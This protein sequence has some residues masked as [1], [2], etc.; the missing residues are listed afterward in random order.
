[1]AVDRSRSDLAF[2]S[3][4]SRHTKA[5]TAR[6]TE[7]FPW[8]IF[9]VDFRFLISDLQ[10]CRAASYPTA[11]ARTAALRA[12]ASTSAHKRKATPRVDIEVWRAPAHNEHTR[13]ASA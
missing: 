1:M 5:Q 13:P 2:A 3:T 8:S 12:W 9:A 11:I 7:L 10:V 6:T 4:K